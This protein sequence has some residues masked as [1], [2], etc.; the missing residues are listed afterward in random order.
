MTLERFT[1]TTMI[2]SMYCKCTHT[3]T[4]MLGKA[5]VLRKMYTFIYFLLLVTLTHTR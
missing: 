5:L 2:Y 1:V 3:K 4:E